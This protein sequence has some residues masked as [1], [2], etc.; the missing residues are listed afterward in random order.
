METRELIQKLGL[1]SRSALVYLSCLQLGESTV[2][3][4]ARHAK[5]RR[6]TI[7]YLLG[8]LVRDGFLIESKHGKKRYY[9]A[10][11][12]KLLIDMARKNVRDLE[13]SIDEL[14]I[15]K[16]SVLYRPRVLFLHGISGFKEAWKKVFKETKDEYLIVTNPAIFTQ[17][18]KEK[19]IQEEIVKAK[20]KAGLQS[21]HIIVDSEY[22]RKIVKNDNKQNRQSRFLSR[23]YNLIS[24]QII[25]QKFVVFISP[26]EDDLIMIIEDDAIAKTQWAYFENM[27]ERLPDKWISEIK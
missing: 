17:F 1:D 23:K 9:I 4:I 14:N 5:L 7:Y 3:E 18:V 10:A 19:Y 21:R 26:R 25:S 2:L 11:D 27:W 20:L 16:H 8:D 12:P 24:T 22:N 6:T 13:D 15:M